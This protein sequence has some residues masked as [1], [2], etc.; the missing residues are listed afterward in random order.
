MRG[1]LRLLQF[2][3][4]CIGLTLCIVGL[5]VLTGNEWLAVAAIPGG[6]VVGLYMGLT[7]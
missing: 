7:E 1:I 6:A 5:V 3:A 2:Q 4:I